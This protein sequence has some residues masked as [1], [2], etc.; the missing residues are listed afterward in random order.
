VTLCDRIASRSMA[1][2]S[3]PPDDLERV[4]AEEHAATCTACA[5]ALRQG[6][7]LLR[8]VTAELRPEPS[9]EALRRAGFPGAGRLGAARVTRPGELVGRL[10]G[11]LARRPSRRAR[12]G[13][14]A[15]GSGGTRRFGRARLAGVE[16]RRA[17]CRDRHQVPGL[18][19]GLRPLALRVLRGGARRG[20]QAC[21]ARR[22]SGARGKRGARG[23]GRASSHL[24]RSRRAPAPVCFPLHGRRPRGAARRANPGPPAG[25]T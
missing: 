10:C 2:V 7:Q 18:R 11:G 17:P 23:P 8:L 14:T 16:H 20:A 22:C 24:P 6:G 9:A 5:R 25:V 1:L 21:L 19:A 15:N 3:M 4:A 13:G 12:A